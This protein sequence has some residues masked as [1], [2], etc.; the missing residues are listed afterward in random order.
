MGITGVQQSEVNHKIFLFTS[1]SVLCVAGKCW[2]SDDA[3]PNPISATAP[4]SLT[5]CAAHLVG[6]VQEH[7][8]FVMQHKQ[9]QRQHSHQKQ[10]RQ[11]QRAV[12]EAALQTQQQPDQSKQ[13]RDKITRSSAGLIDLV[14]GRSCSDVCVGDVGR[15]V[16]S[17]IHPEQLLP[18]AVPA[19]SVSACAS[20]QQ[21]PQALPAASSMLQDSQATIKYLTH[22][23]Q[24]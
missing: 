18:A 15:P 2:T 12:T 23:G 7:V 24:C 21:Q 1:W 17:E 11:A 4:G 19:A 13:G 16:L 5:D 14:H 22:P 3:Q 6:L 10:Q 8:V 20:A 9:Q